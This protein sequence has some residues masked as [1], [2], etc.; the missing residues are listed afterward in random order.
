MNFNVQTYFLKRGIIITFLLLGTILPGANTPNEKEKIVSVVKQF[1]AVLESRD[2]KDAQKILIP[3]GV[4]ISLREEGKGET[5]RITNFQEFMDSFSKWK[6][7]YKEIMSNPKVLIHNGIA[8]LW[9][10]YKFYVNGKFSHCGV[11]AFSLIKTDNNW[12]IAGIIYTVEK[13]GCDQ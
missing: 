11:D 2:V 10:D 6:D 13:S 1:F 12:K 9:A 3:K 8:V 5:V 7:N 4:S